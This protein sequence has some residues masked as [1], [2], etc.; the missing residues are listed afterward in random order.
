MSVTTAASNRTSDV[1]AWNRRSAIC[2]KEKFI[3]TW[4]LQSWKIEQIGGELT[5]STLGSNPVGCI[6]YQRD[7]HMSVNLMRSDR[8]NFV[9]NNLMDATWKSNQ[10]SKG[11]LVTVAHTR[12]TH[13]EDLLFI[14][15]R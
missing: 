12:S 4:T 5:D 3:G 8:L 1:F 2:I 10:A 13:R 9:S 15:S 7:G 11:M 6:M 14:T